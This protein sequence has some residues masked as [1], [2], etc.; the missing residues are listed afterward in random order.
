[1]EVC[2]RE[3]S[4][5]FVLGSI[6]VKPSYPSISP[7]VVSTLWEH[8]VNSDPTSM[9][10]TSVDFDLLQMLF[11]QPKLPSGFHIITTRLA[12]WG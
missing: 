2:I 9:L 12:G 7:F 4:C 10:S 8:D 1:M 5:L 11:P 3:G 6:D